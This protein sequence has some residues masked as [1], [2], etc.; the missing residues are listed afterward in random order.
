MLVRRNLLNL[1]KRFSSNQATGCYQDCLVSLDESTGIQTIKLNREKRLN[2][3]NFSLYSVIPR[4]L[5]E[6]CDDP[7]IKMTVLTGSGKYFT[8]G[9]DLSDFFEKWYFAKIAVTKSFKESS[10]QT[11]MRPSHPKMQQNSRL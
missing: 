4:V 10:F 2:A 9:N 3:I 7:K 1:T 5:T 11:G 8:S 6:A